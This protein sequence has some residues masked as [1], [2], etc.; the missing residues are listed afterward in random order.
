[1]SAKK[2]CLLCYV[3][4]GGFR[5][6]TLNLYSLLERKGFEVTLVFLRELSNI[7]DNL[8]FTITNP[9]TREKKH[10]FRFLFL[11]AANKLLMITHNDMKHR[12]SYDMLCSQIK[13][14]KKVDECKPLDLYSYDCVI[15]TEEMFCT[16][17]LSKK[18]LAKK[19]IAF[20]HPDYKA[21]GFNKKIDRY[22]FKEID[23]LFA[24]SDS[25]KVSLEN[26]FPDFKKKTLGMRN[27]IDYVNIL[28]KSNAYDC[29]F[30]RNT[31]NIITVCRLDNK[32]KALDR[33]L[34]I[35]LSLKKEGYSF[36]WRIIGSGDYGQTMKEFIFD[37]NLEQ[38]LI[39]LGYI[40]NPMPYIKESDLFVLQ[41]Y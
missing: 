37:N 40:D 36:V 12:Q 14:A 30:N 1:M 18:V 33:L 29:G 35:A 5:S 10:N 39:M 27:S 6:F 8:K 25:G 2:V 11:K 23:Y 21:A 9:K 20:I 13:A 4:A 22:Y 7:P 38:N 28:K 3:F 26:S 16:Y 15:S 19:K 41:S 24:V 17:F 31:F 32:S 34:R